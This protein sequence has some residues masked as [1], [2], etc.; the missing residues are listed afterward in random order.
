[1]GWEGE[2]LY[3]K[4]SQSGV[5]VVV[6]HV[7]PLGVVLRVGPPGKAISPPSFLDWF[8]PGRGSKREGRERVS[9]WHDL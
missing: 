5:D 6:R 9:E 2:N 7:R 4:E 3:F 8:G 1:M